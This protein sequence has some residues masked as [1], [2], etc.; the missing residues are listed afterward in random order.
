[1]SSILT[2]TRNTR[3][4]LPD[5]LRFV[6]SDAPCNLTE[7]EIRWLKYNGITTVIDLRSEEEVRKRPTIFSQIDGFVYMSMPVTGGN[8]IPKTA[9][10]VPKSYIDMIDGQMDIIIETIISANTNVLY[11]CSAGKDRTGV[12]SAILLFKLGYDENYIIEDYMQ[13]AEE[14]R[15]MLEDFAKSGLADLSVITPRPENIRAVISE[16]KRRSVLK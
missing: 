2:T 12:V 1:M 8:A 6:R 16:M 7:D 10:D 3:P 5:S 9:E 13:S 11:F 4:I 14:L 15:Q